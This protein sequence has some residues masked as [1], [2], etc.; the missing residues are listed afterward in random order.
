MEEY[1]CIVALDMRDLTILA[2]IGLTKDKG[3]AWASHLEDARHIIENK[4][5]SA[6]EILSRSIKGIEGLIASL[7]RLA[8]A[9]NSDVVRTTTD[10]LKSAADRLNALPGEHAVRMS[11]L[12]KLGKCR[13]D[14][15]DKIDR[16]RGELAYMRAFTIN[17]RIVAG[18]QGDVGDEFAIFAQDIADG[19]AKCGD[20]LHKV[21]SD[22]STLQTRLDMAREQNLQL[23]QDIRKYF[24]ALP[25]ELVHR[26]DDFRVHYSN[27]A[28]TARQVTELA[29]DIRKI[30]SRTLLALQIGDITRQRIEHIQYAVEMAFLPQA[31]DDDG[32]RTLAAFV[33]ALEGE[34]LAATG[35]DFEREVAEINRSMT[36]MGEMAG[37]LLK[38]HDLAFNKGGDRQGGFLHSLAQHIQQARTLAE[39]VADADTSALVTGRETSAAAEQLNR[40]ISDIQMLKNDVQYMALNTTLK[41][42]QIGEAGRPLS[43]VALEL[44]EHA[45]R[46]DAAATDSLDVLEHLLAATATLTEA[47]NAQQEQTG[48]KTAVIQALDAAAVRIVEAGDKTEADINAIAEKGDA[49]M[50]TL[51]VSA[52]TLNFHEE[53]GVIIGDVTGELSAAGTGLE[54]CPENLSAAM[55][56]VLTVLSKKYT[57]AQERDIQK[58]FIERWN[59]SAAE[60]ENPQNDDLSAE[61]F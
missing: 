8:A 57:M 55:Q 41:S 18:S 25:D 36:T 15:D 6:G 17:V 1:A 29:R 51:E 42:C 61:L 45:N 24:P 3:V 28:E 33:Y 26:A 22:S 5:L 56:D 12:E 30:V 31:L 49:V 50:N 16:M 21:E 19:I 38:L 53:I 13:A 37:Q 34:Q 40:R 52:R 32:R 7:E 23:G 46:L 60:A 10:D 2:D 9:L 11:N 35:A 43:V 58:L 59:L 27:V 14:L 54:G 48:A 20:E 44:R 39:T 47:D 4:F